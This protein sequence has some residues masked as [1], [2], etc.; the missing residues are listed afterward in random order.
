MVFVEED[1]NERKGAIYLLEKDPQGTKSEEQIL[2]ENNK[3]S[4]NKSANERKRVKFENDINKDDPSKTTAKVD[5]PSTTC[6]LHSQIGGCDYQSR[7]LCKRRHPRKLC[8]KFRDTGY[9]KYTVEE[10]WYRHPIEVKISH[11]RKKEQ[12]K[13]S[14]EWRP[15]QAPTSSWRADERNSCLQ[16]RG[17]NWGQTEARQYFTPPMT[18]YRVVAGTGW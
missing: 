18:P 1:I 13:R 4:M 2:L 8:F 15:E 10:C 16:F 9:C 17:S 6:S 7:G 3:N 14:A 5:I 12:L 11:H